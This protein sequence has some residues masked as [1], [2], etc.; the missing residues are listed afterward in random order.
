MS[1]E[2]LQSTN[3]PRTTITFN[4]LSPEQ[5]AEIYWIDY[6]GQRIHY[7]TLEPSASYQQSTYVNHPWEVIT[8]GG[9]RASYLPVDYLPNFSVHIDSASE[10]LES[11]SETNSSIFTRSRL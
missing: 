7:K 11:R 6:E 2:G 1:V 3:G 10:R 9:E 8:S 4:N 5:S